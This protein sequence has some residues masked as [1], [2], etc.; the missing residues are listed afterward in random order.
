M[1]V[2]KAGAII[3]N[4][5]YTKVL[6]VMNQ[7]SEYMCEY[8]WG[9][10]KGHKEQKESNAKCCLREVRE[11]VG[12]NLRLSKFEHPYIIV[13]DTCYYLFCFNT[14]KFYYPRDKNEISKVRWK[15][16]RYIVNENMNRG[17]R[18]VVESWDEIKEIFHEYKQA[19]K[20]RQY[21]KKKYK[22]VKKKSLGEQR[23]DVDTFSVPFV[24]SE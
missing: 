16:L 11:E 12:I 7:E 19:N 6:C 24:D 5:D 2:T 20:K 17:L 10:P 15:K 4:H 18:A 23:M 22:N 13:Y 14:Q 3:T 1:R 9:L 21:H 8:K